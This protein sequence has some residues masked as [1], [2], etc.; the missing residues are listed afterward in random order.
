MEEVYNLIGKC[1]HIDNPELMLGCVK[2]SITRVRDLGQSREGVG[3]ANREPV[4]PPSK[5]E[6]DVRQ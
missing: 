6:F 2:T 4:P 3:R 5:P 1:H